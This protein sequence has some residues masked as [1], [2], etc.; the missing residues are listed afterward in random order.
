MGRNLLLVT[1]SCQL[2]PEA[3]YNTTGIGHWK[4]FAKSALGGRVTA[5]FVL[6][7]SALVCKTSHVCHGPYYN[8]VQ[9]KMTQ[10]TK[11]LVLLSDAARTRQECRLLNFAAW[12]GVSVKTVIVAQGIDHVPTL[13]NRLRESDDSVCCLAVSAETLAVMQESK[14]LG[15]FE[16]TVQRHCG[17]LLVFGFQNSFR[18]DS[19]ASWLTNGAVCRVAS[20]EQANN[21]FEMPV[22]GRHFSRQLAGLNF[23]T[24]HAVSCPTFVLAGHSSETTVVMRANR[25]PAFLTFLQGSCRLFLMTPEVPDV[26]EK[27]SRH[28]GME[29]HYHQVIP[30]LIFLRF[31]FSDC[32]WHSIQSTARFI[33]DDPLL[34]PTYGF[35]DYTA[36]LSSM[37]RENFGTSVAFIPWNYRRT[38]KQTVTRLFGNG[39]NFS[40]C[41]HGCDHTNREFAALDE[42][43]LRQ[44]ARLALARMEQHERRTNLSFERVM[45]FPQGRFSRS[46]ISALRSNGYLAAVNSTCFPTDEELVGLTVADFLRPAVTRY[47]GL[48]IFLRRY[49]RNLIDAAFDLFL[50]HPVLLVEHHQYFKD[51]EERLEQFVRGLQKIEPDLSWPLLS[52]Q[53]TRSCIMRSVSS[54]SSIVEFFTNKFQFRNSELSRRKLLLRKHEPDP[55]IISSVLV[56]GTP[57]SFSVQGEF[58]QFETEPDARA[59]VNVEVLDH[60]RAFEE[61]SS[62]SITYGLGVLVRRGLSELRDNALVRRPVLLNVATQ[63]ARGLKVT[64]ES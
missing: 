16:G 9:K 4:F 55:S 1:S 11:S 3:H 20:P 7:Q 18:H 47:H 10:P 21:A 19:V 56:N 34:R 36:L 37:R 49:P 38:S 27:L 13:I 59:A 41:V 23:S 24:Q 22:E 6:H 46:A 42:G 33:I 15:D 50:G 2:R 63:L 43:V 25:G 62:V 28:N 29:Q 32:C 5:N 57:V 40:I 8:P 58:I 52:S 30:L 54:R 31:C 35:L 44:K 61:E 26:D 53:L 12:M 48:P 64:G 45:V 39:D 14:Q 51:G 60:G 17:E